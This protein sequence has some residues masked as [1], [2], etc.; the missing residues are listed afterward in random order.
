[1]ARGPEVSR[2]TRLAE[3]ALC[4]KPVGLEI[5]VGPARAGGG[6]PGA[7]GAL[8]GC[9][10]GA[11]GVLRGVL[12]IGAARAIAAL[13]RQL[14]R[15]DQ[16]LLRGAA[17]QPL[18]VHCGITG[19]RESNDRGGRS[20]LVMPGDDLEVVVERGE[21]GRG[22]TP[23]DVVGWG[24]MRSRR[25]VTL[26]G[27]LLVACRGGG[28]SDAKGAASGAPADLDR[29]EVDA[30]CGWRSHCGPSCGNS[31]VPFEM[32]TRRRAAAEDAACPPRPERDY[33][34][35]APPP[36]CH[37]DV[38]PACVEHACVAR[39]ESTVLDGEGSYGSCNCDGCGAAPDP[40]D[41]SACG[42]Y[43]QAT[44]EWCCARHSGLTIGATYAPD[45]ASVCAQRETC[46][47]A[48]EPAARDVCKLPATPVPPPTGEFASHWLG[49]DAPGFGWRLFVGRGTSLGVIDAATGKTTGVSISGTGSPPD[50]DGWPLQHGRNVIVSDDNQLAWA[51]FDS[52]TSLRVRHGFF[53]DDID[54]VRGASDDGTTVLMRVLDGAASSW[55][56]I[57][58]DPARAV[59]HDPVLRRDVANAGWW[60]ELAPDGRSAMLQ[61]SCRDGSC[62]EGIM[63][64]DVET[65]VVADLVVPRPI[66]GTH[67]PNGDF[68]LSAAASTCAPDSKT[69]STDILRVPAGDLGAAAKIWRAGARDASVARTSNRVA[70]VQA[71]SVCGDPLGMCDDPV[72]TADTDG[73]NAAVIPGVSAVGL[74]RW[75]LSPDASWVAFARKRGEAWVLMICP[76]GGG[77]CQEGETAVT[78]GWAR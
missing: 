53:A 39:V 52:A 54:E 74:D 47:G 34:A 56:V 61:R 73:G 4:E 11:P 13:R 16:R 2:H 62:T 40:N 75:A 78:Y 31:S 20:S 9:S 29:C 25:T 63:R 44:W 42:A 28:P 26:A 23:S 70:F 50:G 18:V 19:L 58:L 17:T 38:E 33:I 55:R 6:E 68:L 60:G 24:R 45:W 5:D 71:D 37:L 15:V 41:A 22:A 65:G 7:P 3:G 21:G 64:L 67:L 43:H 14:H 8:R 76:T 69:C 48:D 77:E 49:P 59:V 35:C 27:C 57:R 32:Q 12:R 36:P 66:R 30:D 46:R 1:V 72:W 51:E 10:G